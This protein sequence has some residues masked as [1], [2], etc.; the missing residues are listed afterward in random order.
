MIDYNNLNDIDVN[1]ENIDNLIQ[2]YG[3]KD[4]DM[5]IVNNDGSY[6]VLDM[7]DAEILMADPEFAYKVDIGFENINEFEYFAKKIL[8]NKEG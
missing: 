2:E 7:D 6:V 1:D 5:I 8:N 4:D 3:I